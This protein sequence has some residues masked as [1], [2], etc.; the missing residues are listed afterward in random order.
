MPLLVLFLILLSSSTF[1][2][3]TIGESSKLPLPRF[4][5]MAADKIYARTGPG[6]R[7]PVKWVYHRKNM[8]IEVIREFDTWRKIRDID[9]EESWVHQSLLSGRRFAIL[10]ESDPV[11]LQKTTEIDSRPVAK[12]EPQAI[13]RIEKCDGKAWCKLSLDGY[14]GWVV[15]NMLWGIYDQERIE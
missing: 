12:I 13:L 7:Y 11:I 9:G 15:Q 10:S 1:A 5:S 3:E 4:A 2:S 8:P 14:K 6:T